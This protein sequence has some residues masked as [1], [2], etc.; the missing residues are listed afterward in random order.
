VPTFNSI[1]KLENIWKNTIQVSMH[2]SLRL[3]LHGGMKPYTWMLYPAESRKSDF[4]GVLHLKGMP[5][6]GNRS[7]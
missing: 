1:D 6:Y 3:E 7:D 2:K 5:E 4:R